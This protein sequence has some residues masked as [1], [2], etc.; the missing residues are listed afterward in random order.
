MNAKAAAPQ[1]AAA[2]FF[3]QKSERNKFEIFFVPLHFIISS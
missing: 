1:K 2:F 3:P